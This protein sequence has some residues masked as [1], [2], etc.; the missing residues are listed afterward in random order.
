MVE[1]IGAVIF[2]LIIDQLLL[3]SQRKRWRV[4]RHEIEHI[5]SRTLNTLRDDIL[6]NMFTYKPV[7]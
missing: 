4:V 3:K 7:Y 2:I 6:L 5:L 1:L